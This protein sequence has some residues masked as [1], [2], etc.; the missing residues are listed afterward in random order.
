VVN[1]ALLLI[2]EVRKVHRSDKIFMKTGSIRS[3]FQEFDVS[4]KDSISS[5]NSVVVG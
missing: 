4:G 3:L 2:I 5:E 1:K